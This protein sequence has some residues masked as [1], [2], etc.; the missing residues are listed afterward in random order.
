M[1]N[2]RQDHLMMVKDI[3]L[4]YAPEIKVGVFGSRA[5]EK[6][7]PHSDLDLI[8]IGKTKIDLQTMANLET[9]FE[10]SDLPFRVDIV[11]WNRIEED[12]KKAIEKDIQYF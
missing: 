5:T 4:K 12:F 7:K 1:I 2:L 9:A 10:D 8:L 11:D 6:I 3:L